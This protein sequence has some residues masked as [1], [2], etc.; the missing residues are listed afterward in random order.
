MGV[1]SRTSAAIKTTIFLFVAPG[2]TAGLIPWLIT[3]WNVESGYDLIAAQ[4]IGVVL[5]IVGAAFLLSAFARFVIEGIGTPAPVAPTQKLVV[6]GSYRYVRNPMYVAVTT[7]IVGQSLLFGSWPVVFYAF[8]FWA[9]TASFVRLYEEPKL[10]SQFGTEYAIY[11]Q[12]VNGWIP[13]L[14][15][16]NK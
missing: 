1:S 10:M 16:W 9:T 14:K 3:R 13:R 5:V 8:L 4:V 6:G 11:K 2:T 12:N 15:P 7:T